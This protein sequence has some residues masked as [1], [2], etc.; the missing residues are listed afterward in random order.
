MKLI[1]SFTPNTPKYVFKG[2]AD[3]ATNTPKNITGVDYEVKGRSLD[4]FTSVFINKCCENASQDLLDHGA[5]EWKYLLVPHDHV[6]ENFKLSDNR[7]QFTHIA[8]V[9]LSSGKQ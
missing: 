7:M 6:K 3:L 2:I 9:S 4:V 1:E 8:M 5:K